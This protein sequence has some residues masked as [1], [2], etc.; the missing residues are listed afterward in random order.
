MRLYL[1]TYRN[2]L[3]H[4]SPF[5][6]RPIPWQMAFPPLPRHAGTLQRALLPA[7][8]SRTRLGHAQAARGHPTLLPAAEV[9]LAVR[10]FW[11]GELGFQHG[12]SHKGFQHDGE[13]RLSWCRD[14]RA[15]WALHG[16]DSDFQ[17]R[18]E[19]KGEHGV[20]SFRPAAVDG[21]VSHAV[22]IPCWIFVARE[23]GLHV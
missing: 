4:L 6:R 13:S 3:S 8:L 14:E 1:P 9:L 7:Q 21:G 16:A 17:A 5:S 18:S 20:Q 19:S 11:V 2:E 10:L 22:C 23:V 15:L 12:I